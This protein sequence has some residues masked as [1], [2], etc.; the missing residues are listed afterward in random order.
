MSWITL[1]MHGPVSEYH[2][3]SVSFK[4]SLDNEQ[5]MSL[6]GF[7]Q[8][9]VVLFRRCLW[10]CA[11]CECIMIQQLEITYKETAH[12]CQY[13]S[14]FS[15]WQCSWRW[16]AQTILCWTRSTLFH[17]RLCGPALTQRDMGLSPANGLLLELKGLGHMLKLQVKI[18]V[19]ERH[20]CLHCKGYYPELNYKPINTDDHS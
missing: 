5:D 19:A 9:N 11:T 6:R 1:Q 7:M 10:H 4:A 13:S 18:D 14:G 8:A 17:I 20:Y 3:L 12:P 16:L 15:N 2:F